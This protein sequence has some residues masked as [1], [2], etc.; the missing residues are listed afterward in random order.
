MTARVS[1]EHEHDSESS[2]AKAMHA[3]DGAHD[4]DHHHDACLLTAASA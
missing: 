2:H 4:A 3:E 1:L